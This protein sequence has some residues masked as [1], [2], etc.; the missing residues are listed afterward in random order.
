MKNK[1]LTIACAAMLITGASANAA[2]NEPMPIRDRPTPEMMEAQLA[3]R[4]QLNSDQRK[5]IRE[6]REQDQVEMRQLMEKMKEIRNEMNRIRQANI[7]AFEAQLTPEQK[8]EFDKIKAERKAHQMERMGKRK[9]RHM[10]EMPHMK[11]MPHDMPPMAGEMRMPEPP[12]EPNPVLTG[13]TPS[14]VNAT[15]TPTDSVA[16]E[17]ESK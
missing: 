11:D 12:E 17:P 8:A 14:P 2:E 13:D 3:D 5:V 16:A 1:F 15:V 10:R 9:M 6:R 4:L 7:E